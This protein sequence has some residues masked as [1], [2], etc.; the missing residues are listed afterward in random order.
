MRL[1][2]EVVEQMARVR[3]AECG[4]PS[5]YPDGEF[6]A[7]YE[8]HFGEHIWEDWKDRERKIWMKRFEPVRYEMIYGYREEGWK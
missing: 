3:C 1:S 4:K 7:H 5:I 6:F 2:N 8:S